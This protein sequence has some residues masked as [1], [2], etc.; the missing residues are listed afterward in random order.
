MQPTAAPAASALLSG[1]QAELSEFQEL[2]QTLLAEQDCL[3]RADADGLHQLVEIKFR[4]IERLNALAAQRAGYLDS[5]QLA[6]DRRGME[7][8]LATHAGADRQSASALWQAVL[9]AAARARA[10]NDS[11]GGL[12]GV[13]LNH[14]QAA[15]AALQSAASS[16]SIYGPD[17]QPQ[18]PAGQRDLGQ[19]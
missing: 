7:K 11:N 13:R 18:S 6:S 14:N 5:L 1:L 16:L 8:W 10:L 15:L 9:E 3:L 17:G 12:I 4:Q 19:A 2:R